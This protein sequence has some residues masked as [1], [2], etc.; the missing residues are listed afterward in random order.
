MKCVG[1]EECENSACL[2]DTLCKQCRS[3]VDAGKRAI[4]MIE[5]IKTDHPDPFVRKHGH[6]DSKSN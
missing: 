6:D 1:D 4:E 3:A 5:K 2:P